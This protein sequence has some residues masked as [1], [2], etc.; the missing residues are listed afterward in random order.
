MLVIDG[1]DQ[2]LP[3]FRR[4][5]VNMAGDFREDG[6]VEIFRNDRAV[7][8]INVEI[9]DGRD[10]IAFMVKDLP[11]HALDRRNLEARFG[12][13][14]PAVVQALDIINLIEGK[15]VFQFHFLKSIEG[16]PAQDVAVDEIEDAMDRA[17]R[18]DRNGASI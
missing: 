14:F 3:F 11:H 15:E 16:L 10:K 1:I 2:G 8:I 18:R 12:R 13:D 6:A 7:E 4:R 17:E 5:R 9:R